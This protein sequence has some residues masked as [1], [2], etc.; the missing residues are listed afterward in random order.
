MFS[1]DFVTIYDGETE[2]DSQLARLTG[3]SE[4]GNVITATGNK[5]LIHLESDS[6]FTEAGFEIQFNAG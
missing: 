5:V 3:N 2:F 6:S 4:N 1:Y